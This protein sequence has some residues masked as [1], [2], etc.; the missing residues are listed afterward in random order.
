MFS[1]MPSRLMQARTEIEKIHTNERNIRNFHEMKFLEEFIVG[2]VVTKEKN[3]KIKALSLSDKELIMVVEY[4]PYNS[5]KVDMKNLYQ[6]FRYRTSVLLCEILYKQWQGSYDTKDCNKF[7]S[8]LIDQDMNFSKMF[9]AFS[10]GI[11][12]YQEILNSKSVV[13]SYTNLLKKKQL[14]QKSELEEW[15]KSV[16]IENESRLFYDLQSLF[17]TYCGKEVYLDMDKMN[18]LDVV[19][20]Y[21]DAD[22]TLFLA[23][24]LEKLT[25]REL[26]AFDMLAV[27]LSKRL[28]DSMGVICRNIFSE[29]PEQLYIKYK[30][31]INTNTI[32]KVFGNDERSR[33]WKQFRFVSVKKIPYSDSVIMEFEDKY[34]TEFLGRAAGPMYFYEKGIFEEK[35]CKIYR[36]STNQELKN[37]IFKYWKNQE[38]QVMKENLIWDRKEHQPSPGWQSKVEYFLIRNNITKKIL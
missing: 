6:I 3:L 21:R 14:Q 2:L 28:G 24:F 1:F 5:F 18:L 15:S 26:Q 16:G 4:L 13:K 36:T 25:L 12:D 32:N 27:K 33:F 34:V 30:D 38:N 11:K 8:E 10:M 9:S 19:S 29:I 22:L 31:W 35:I 23:N 17:Y 37:I 20:R 7:I